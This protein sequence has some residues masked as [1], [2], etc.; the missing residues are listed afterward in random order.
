M[1]ELVYK[2]GS[3]VRK[4]SL[5]DGYPQCIEDAVKAAASAAVP[6]IQLG[7]AIDSA[8]DLVLA[9]ELAKSNEEADGASDIIAG[10]SAATVALALWRTA[11]PNEPEALAAWEAAR[12]TVNAAID[13]ASQQPLVNDPRPVPSPIKMWA[14]RAVL[15]S[16]G[17]LDQASAIVAAAGGEVQQFWEYGD[18]M[19]RDAPTLAQL[20]AALHL[21]S[22]Q[23]DDMFRK[24]DAIVL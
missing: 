11:K 20:S 8:N 9:Y 16:L 23:I 22:T 24:A 12:D 5:V 2:N 17:L 1:L 3:C 21:T 6:A 15:A 4:W 10:A 18:V 19:H 13:A 7:L 14:A